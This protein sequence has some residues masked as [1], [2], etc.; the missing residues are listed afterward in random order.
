MVEVASIIHRIFY[1]G[2]WSALVAIGTLALAY[3]TVRVVHQAREQTAAQWMPVLVAGETIMDLGGTIPGIHVADEVLTLTVENIRR[4]PALDVSGHVEVEGKIRAAAPLLRPLA[5][6]GFMLLSWSGGYDSSDRIQGWVDYGDVTERANR[7]TFGVPTTSDALSELI[8]QH[9][10]R[11][12]PFVPRWLDRAP[13]WL[14]RRYVR[15]KLAGSLP[16][17]KKEAP[18]KQRQ[19]ERR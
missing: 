9:F 12:P 13:R 16:S 1:W 7:T 10:A 5:P 2:G 11:L 17:A 6:G 14:V 4:G 8:V 3:A 18:P 19:R 15:R